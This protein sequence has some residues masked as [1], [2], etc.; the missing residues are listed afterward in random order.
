MVM[1]VT[2]LERAIIALHDYGTREGATAKSVRRQMMD[3]GFTNKEIT[4]AAQAMEGK[5]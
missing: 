3:A 4:A 2:R 1:M 5:K